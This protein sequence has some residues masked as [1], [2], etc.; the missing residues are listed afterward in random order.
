MKKSLIL[1]SGGLDSTV[2]LHD[3]IN[4]KHEIICLSFNYGSKQNFTELKYAQKYLEKLKIKHI[5][6]D[7]DLSKHLISSLT[8]PEIKITNAKS[9][10]VPFRNTIMLSIALGITESLDY[11]NIY[12]GCNKDDQKDYRL[13]I[14]E[15]N[16]RLI[17]Q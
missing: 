2:L 10:I 11:D 1:Y 9:T 15:K 14:M 3:L 8:N 16:Y 12:I 6:I 7:I 4:K 17:F 13:L 5:V